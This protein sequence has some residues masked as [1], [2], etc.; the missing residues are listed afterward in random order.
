MVNLKP[1][2][3]QGQRFSC[4]PCRKDLLF[5]KDQ[6]TTCHNSSSLLLGPNEELCTDVMSPKALQRKM[7]IF[8]DSCQKDPSFVQMD[9][10]LNKEATDKEWVQMHSNARKV[11]SKWF[12]HQKLLFI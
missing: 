6:S 7:V 11:P 3:F 8:Q 9:N 4:T 10:M 5:T 2:I 12:P 1:G